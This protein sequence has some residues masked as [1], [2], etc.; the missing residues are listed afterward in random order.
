MTTP[1][2]VVARAAALNRAMRDLCPV[3]KL[4]ASLP[5]RYLPGDP[6]QLRVLEMRAQ[7][8]L[9]LR[10]PGDAEMPYRWYW[11]DNVRGKNGRDMLQTLYDAAGKVVLVKR[12]RGTKWR[13]VKLNDYGD[14]RPTTSRPK[15]SV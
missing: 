2:R 3:E 8:R 12:L 11:G 5:T 13:I 1:D 7:L 9:P 10:H 6:R 15:S 14:L 4:N